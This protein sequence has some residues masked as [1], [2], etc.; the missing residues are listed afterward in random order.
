[1]RGTKPETPPAAGEGEGAAPTD[2]TEACRPVRRRLTPD[3]KGKPGDYT[4]T[5]AELDGHGGTPV[6]DHVVAR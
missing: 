3:L 6:Y 5:E 4:K 1:M 2:T